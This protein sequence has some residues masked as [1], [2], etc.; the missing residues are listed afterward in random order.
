VDDL[1]ARAEP[2]A[3][4][5]REAAEP[6][7]FYEP[8]VLLPTLRAFS[9]DDLTVVLVWAGT[10]KPEL[11]GMFPLLRGRAGGR[12][13][14]SYLR[15]WA[16]TYSYVPVPLVHRE[17]GPEVIGAF[18]DWIRGAMGFLQLLEID[19][20]P[21]GGAFHRLLAEELARR[22]A[23]TFVRD[24][25][26]RALLAPSCDA[27]AYQ[28]GALAPKRRKELRRQRR[29]LGELGKLEFVSFGEG[30]DL[31]QWLRDFLALE[32]GG[33]KGRQGTALSSRER[34]A[35]F[36]L[37][38]ARGCDRARRFGATAIRLDGRAIAI[39]ILLRSGNGAYAFK[40]GY[41][42]AYARFSPGVLLELDLVERVARGGFVDWIDSSAT[43]DHPMINR[44]WTE[45]RDIETWTVGLSP[46]GRVVLSV[47]RPARWLRARFG[48]RR[49]PEEATWE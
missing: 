3:E 49:A 5:A 6:N 20:L 15:I 18:F 24:R 45:R 19:K 47:L 16:H 23:K 9:A 39:Q 13:G 32:S 4:L 37:E 33:W 8:Q 46:A 22:G 7:V 1:G 17:H 28:A 38:M 27:E 36:F 26:T 12:F 25:W 30:E 10:A 35:E 48:K 14:F 31:E 40:I 2:W 41:D 21:V 43:R 44:L 29:R 34:H 11:W 42:E